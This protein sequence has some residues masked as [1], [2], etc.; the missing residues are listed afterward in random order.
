MS[1][2]IM[3]QRMEE[4]L[5]RTTLRSMRALC[6]NQDAEAIHEPCRHP[7]AL[8]SDHDRFARSIVESGICRRDVGAIRAGRGR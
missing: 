8:E 1:D 6:R 5:L 7:K 3:S 4:L 2:P